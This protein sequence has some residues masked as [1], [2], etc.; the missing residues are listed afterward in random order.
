MGMID[1]LLG[2]SPRRHYRRRGYYV[3]RKV[4]PVEQIDALADTARN[5]MPAYQGEH[6]R[7]NGR[8]EAN[9]FYSGTQLIR[10]PPF[11]LHLPLSSDLRPLSVALQALITAPALADRLRELDGAERYHINQTLLFFAAQ[12]T[13]FHLDSW[14]LDTVPHGGA[15]TLWIPLQDMTF[16][17]GLPCVIPWPQGKVVTE[18]ELGWTGGGPYGERYDHY[19]QALSE[20]LLGDSPEVA[21]SLVRKGDLIV[22]SSLTPHFSLPSQPFPTERLSL[23]VLLRPAHHRWGNF[24]DQPADHPTKRVIRMTDRFSYFISEDICR[25][26]G[27]A[28]DPPDR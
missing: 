14:A 20:K 26:Y 8:A 18:A 27:I 13:G 23:Q 5:M 15:H 3:F 19:Q 28:G 22:W 21:A 1:S 24:I 10:N 25:D 2:D 17:S 6:L 11:N 7:Q 9:D 4:F 12:T 16:K